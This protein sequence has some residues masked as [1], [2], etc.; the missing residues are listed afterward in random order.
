VAYIA[1]KASLEREYTM[2]DV[3]HVPLSDTI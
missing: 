1:D 3:S 2:S